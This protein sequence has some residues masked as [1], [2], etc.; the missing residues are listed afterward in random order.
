MCLKKFVK[1][2]VERCE[3]WK[4]EVFECLQSFHCDRTDD[5]DRDCTIVQVGRLAEQE[6]LDQAREPVVTQSVCARCRRSTTS[7]DCRQ[8]SFPCRWGK[9]GGGEGD[10]PNFRGKCTRRPAG[11][12]S[13][14]VSQSF[15]PVNFPARKGSALRIVR[16]SCLGKKFPEV[17]EWM[18]CSFVF[19]V[20]KVWIVRV[21]LYFSVATWH[22]RLTDYCTIIFVN[23]S[24]LVH[25][26]PIVADF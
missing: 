11:R 1:S 7:N 24:N 10:F 2:I 23:V 19:E 21:V 5:D 13:R 26:F 18:V 14:K 9:W 12:S 15:A 6:S 16:V 17:N 20:L 25:F 8:H 3:Y 22:G 4:F